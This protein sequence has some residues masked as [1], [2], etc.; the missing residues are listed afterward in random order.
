MA[1]AGRSTGW[2]RGEQPVGAISVDGAVGGDV[3]AAGNSVTLG[4][5]AD[6]GGEFRYDAEEFTRSDDA[7]VEGGVVED[8]SLGGDDGRFGAA[9]PSWAGAIYGFLTSLLL[10]A[11]L[12]L[13]FPRFSEAVAA[14]AIAGP[15]VAGGVGLLT[16]IAVPIL[17]VLV[18][19]TI[20]GIP[21]A[22]AGFALYVLALWIASVYGKYAVGRWVLGRGGLG[23]RWLALLLGLVAFLLV[24]L[25]P[26]VG[27]LADFVALLLGLGA[28][29]LALWDRYRGED[30]ATTA[31]GAGAE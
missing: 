24:G 20:V 3:R 25:I 16:L 1:G 31:S 26:I 5:N 8:P 18:T 10:G 19:I 28:L 17:L 14:R 23:N 2:H 13:A 9:L 27:G 12:L 7:T 15:V 4:P 29:V 21:F 30:E 22:I 11:V 6:V